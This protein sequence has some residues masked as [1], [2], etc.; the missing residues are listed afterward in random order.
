MGEI[1]M[2]HTYTYKTAERK[3]YADLDQASLNL[4]QDERRAYGQLFQQADPEGLGVVTGD[5]AVKF[6]E[7]TGLDSSVLG[8]V[9]A[10]F[11]P[12]D[13]TSS[14]VDRRHRFGKL[15]TPKIEA[16]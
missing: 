6:F 14:Y 7:K 3:A 11:R 16:C 5:V 8:E 12:G 13:T 4:T 2:F 1:S 15:V 9:S 10:R